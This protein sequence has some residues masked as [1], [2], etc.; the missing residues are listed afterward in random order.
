MLTTDIFQIV[1]LTIFVIIG[2]GSLIIAIRSK[3]DDD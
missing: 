3:E 2:V 1:F